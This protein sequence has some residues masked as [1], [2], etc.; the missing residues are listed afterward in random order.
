MRNY[1]KISAALMGLLIAA[2]TAAPAICAFAEN[3]GENG[4]AAVLTAENESEESETEEATEETVEETE[5]ET[6]EEAVEEAEEEP[7]EIESGGYTYIVGEDGTATILK[8]DSQDE[9]LEIPETIDG[10]TVTGISDYIFGE[11]NLKKITIPATIENI[12]ESNPFAALLFLEEIVVSEDNENYTVDDGVLYTKDMKTLICYPMMKKGDVFK[13]PDTVETLGIASLYSTQLKEIKIPESIKTLNR[14]CF[15]FNEKLEKI[16]MSNTK[17]TDIPPMCFAECR[18]LT[19]VAFSPD[20]INL[21]LG[22]FMNCASLKNVTL[23]EKLDFIGQS[24]FQGTAISEIVIPKS[25]T[26]I[27]YSAIGYDEDENVIPGTVIVGEPG[28]IAEIY[29]TDSDAEYEVENDFTFVSLSVYEK[30]KEYEALDRKFSGFYEYAVVDGE[31]MITICND[32][33][34]VVEV[35]AEIDGVKITSIYYGAFLSCS[36]KNIVLPDTVTK[37]DENV[38]P[39]HLEHLTISG[40][41]TEIAGEEPFLMLPYLQSITVT[42]G[43]GAY[44]S[45][46]GVLY[47]KDKSCLIAYPAMKLGEE[48]TTPESVKEIAKSGF[49]YNINLKKVKLTAVETIGEYAFEGCT[50]LEEA[51]LPDTLKKVDKNAFLGCSSMPGLR[52]PSSLE[53]IAA[54]AFGYD[55]DE[56]LANDIQANM[57]SYAELGEDVI[58]PYTVIE[59]FKMY[60]EEGSLAHQYATDCGIPVV[61]DTVY[62]AGKNVDKNFIYAIIGAA[63]AVILLIVGIITGKKIKAGKKEKDSEKRKAAAAEKIKAKKE[64][65]KEAEKSENYEGIIETEDSADE[66]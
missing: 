38:F 20:T 61:L 17:L 16:D 23:P 56:E 30:Q 34:D 54:Y 39:E 51:I 44:S 14:H 33:A 11:K 37:I 41:C 62:F 36:S 31:G 45:L 4:D 13:I 19:E 49:N 9:E 21:D 24:A 26:K 50:A 59:G 64:A 48:F 57:D 12:P 15:S 22:A 53:E 8:F 10:I 5:E 60:V 1:K 55:Y 27:N 7:Q 40:N 25:V 2:S 47:N 35:P 42:E 52:V 28:S 63:A 32:V 46:D 66:D 58:M 18:A 3:E 6:V 43:D 29:A 65:E